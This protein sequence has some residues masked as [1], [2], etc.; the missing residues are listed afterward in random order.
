M[1]EVFG[2]ESRVKLNFS[3]WSNKIT[4]ITYTY[5]IIYRSLLFTTTK[6]RFLKW[7]NIG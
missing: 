6:A 2:S 3:K 7:N 1:I 4:I 5:Y